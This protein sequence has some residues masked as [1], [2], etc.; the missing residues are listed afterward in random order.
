MLL[1][2][3]YVWFV[4]YC[5]PSNS[6]LIHSYHLVMCQDGKDVANVIRKLFCYTTKSTTGDFDFFRIFK[7]RIQAIVT[8]KQKIFQDL[9][10]CC[11]TSTILFCIC[12]VFLSF[13]GLSH[14]FCLY[15]RFSSESIGNVSNKKYTLNIQ[16][17]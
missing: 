1:I 11:R 7:R 17:P 14:V 12:P 13:V 2:S 6:K 4:F 3:F 10:R 9:H 16:K 8:V 15:L 5:V